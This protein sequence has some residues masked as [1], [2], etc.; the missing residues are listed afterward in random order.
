MI[1]SERAERVFAHLVKQVGKATPLNREIAVALK[2]KAR[3][4]DNTVTWLRTTG[5]INVKFGGNSRVIEI[6]GVGKTVSRNTVLA[7]SQLP[8]PVKVEES[9]IMAEHSTPCPRCG[10]RSGCGHTAIA[11]SSGRPA[12]WQRFVGA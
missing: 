6:P 8:D 1:P 4:I 11:L 5:R 2:I 10:A 7:K 12:G 9:F 3:D